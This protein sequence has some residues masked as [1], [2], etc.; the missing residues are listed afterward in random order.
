MAPT[1]STREARAMLKE[2]VGGYMRSTRT[3]DPA[4]VVEGMLSMI[5]QGGP[6]R[7]AA[8]LLQA[9][10]LRRALQG[11]ALGVNKGA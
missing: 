11:M 9:D 1:M 8:R 2:R 6:L 7:D 5:G 3:H 4:L 10:Y